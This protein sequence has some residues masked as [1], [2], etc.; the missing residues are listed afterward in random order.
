MKIPK[1]NYTWI[2]LLD[3]TALKVTSLNDII[4]L[5]V[6][7]KRFTRFHYSNSDHVAKAFRNLELF[8]LTT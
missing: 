2:K 8:M 6:F 4:T 7:I 3:K 1:T 5:N